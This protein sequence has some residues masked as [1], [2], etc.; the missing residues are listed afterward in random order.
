VVRH[1]D[2]IIQEAKDRKVANE[3]AAQELWDSGEVPADEPVW[4]PVGLTLNANEGYQAAELHLL[5]RHAIEQEQVIEQQA[6]DLYVTQELL[7][8]AD[9]AIEYYVHKLG[10][11]T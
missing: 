6:D 1:P 8:N 9:G 3:E 4:E 2:D 10:E 11:R 5:A 7:K